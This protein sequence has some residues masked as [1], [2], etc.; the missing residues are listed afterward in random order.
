MLSLSCLLIRICFTFSCTMC[1]LSCHSCISTFL[2]SKCSDVHW[3]TYIG[4]LPF[5]SL[6]FIMD[7][8]HFSFWPLAAYA[9][10]EVGISTGRIHAR[11]PVGVEGL[12]TSKWILRGSGDAASDFGPN[13]GHTFLHQSLPLAWRDDRGGPFANE[14][15]PPAHDRSELLSHSATLLTTS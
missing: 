13:T 9:G 11:G 10:A 8:S 12:L 3:S 14:E 7:N 5:F 6:H 4:R 15:H 2:F 1:T